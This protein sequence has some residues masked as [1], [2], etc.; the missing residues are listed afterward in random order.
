MSNS[1][2]VPSFGRRKAEPDSLTTAPLVQEEA[3]QPVTLRRPF[4]PAGHG[5]L[6]ALCLA[7]LDPGR[8]NERVSALVH[9]CYDAST[10]R[11]C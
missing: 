9:A 8:G 6:R 10:H 11:E 2:L 3:T 4:Q 1:E 5:E 7:K